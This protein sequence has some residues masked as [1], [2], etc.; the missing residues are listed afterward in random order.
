MLHTKCNEIK[1]TWYRHD[2]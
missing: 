1:Q 2:K